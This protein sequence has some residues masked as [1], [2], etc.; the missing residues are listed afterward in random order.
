MRIVVTGGA[1][2]IGSHI[3]DA[4][5]AEGHDVVVLDSLWSHGGGRRENI[6]ENVSFVHMDIRDDGVHRIFAE[7]KPEI[8]CHHAAQHSV[9][10]GARDPKL[11][12]NVNVIGMLNVLDAAVKAGTHKVI[13]AS[14]AATYGD[15]DAMPVDETSPQRPVSPYGIT[16]MVTEHYLRFFASEHGLDYTALRYGNVY[17]P[18]QDP[19]GEAGVIAIFLGK[20]LAKAGIR[21]DWDGEQTRDYVYVGDVVRANVAALAAGSKEIFVI[22]TGKRTSVNDIYRALVEITGFEAPVTHA[23]RRPG[24]A[25][26]VYFNS[27]KA[28]RDLGWEAQVSLV[29][30]MRATYD[31]FREREKFMG[32]VG[33]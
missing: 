12:A 20:F 16:K 3:V 28:K 6:P 27:A 1:G 29:D 26:E 30:G 5:V 8:V 14:S 18:R 13:F 31:Y 15:V 22:G 2:F 4:F 33:A 17:G 32:G 11:D 9:A 10:I 7:F 23:P 19:N 25:R 24:D 21:I